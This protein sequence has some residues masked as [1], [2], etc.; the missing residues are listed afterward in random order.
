M[1]VLKSFP[2]CFAKAEIDF[3][4]SDGIKELTSSHDRLDYNFNFF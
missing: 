4:F 2:I 3:G 1:N